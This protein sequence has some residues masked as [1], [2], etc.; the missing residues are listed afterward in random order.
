[1]FDAEGNQS[2]DSRF[3]YEKSG[4]MIREDWTSS[5]G[6]ITQGIVFQDP[7]AGQWKMTRVDSLG[8]T[9][10]SAGSWNGSTLKLN[11]IAT[12]HLGKQIPASISIRR[13]SNDHLE[14]SFKLDA[15]TNRQQFSASYRRVR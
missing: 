3:S 15:G 12:L 6:S 10:E 4:K 5:D 9:M 11:G 7:N 13:I 1:M 14:T 2:G 8:M